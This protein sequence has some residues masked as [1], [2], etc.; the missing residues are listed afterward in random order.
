MNAFRL[1]ASL[2]DRTELIV[3]VN[4]SASITAC[5]GCSPCM[6][7]QERQVAVGGCRFVAE[8]VPDVPYVMSP[9]Y[10]EYVIS[11]YNID[12]VVHGKFKFRTRSGGKSPFWARFCVCNCDC[13][14]W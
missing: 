5:K 14:G 11:E 7:D 9:E 2:A 1:G 13:P 3:G 6:S 8:V 4:S 10:L 12:Y